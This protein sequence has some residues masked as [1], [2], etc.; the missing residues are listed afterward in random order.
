MINKQAVLEA[1]DIGAYYKAELRQEIKPKT[2]GWA[3]TLCCFHT[4]KN[5]SL[6]VNGENGGWICRAGCGSG[7]I[8]SFHMKKYNLDFKAA[9]KD[10]A[11]R[12]GVNGKKPEIKPF[13]TFDEVKAYKEKDG[14]K[15]DR[16][17]EYQNG[18]PLYLRV[19][20]KNDAGDKTAAYCT[21]TGK[22]FE[23]KRISK[24][25]LYNGTA[26]S[27]RP[28]DPVLKCEG[29]KDTDRLISLGFLAVTAGSVGDINK[30]VLKPLNKRQ[31][32]LCLDNDEP[33]KNATN[34][35][36]A[37][38]H[39]MD[40]N[41]KAISWPAEMNNPELKDVCDFFDKLGRTK[42][43]FLDLVSQAV[44]VPG[45]Q[46]PATEK[47]PG[48]SYFL[49]NYGNLCRYKKNSEGEPIPVKLAN[50]DARILEEA[51]ED[52]GLD[53]THKYTIEGKIKDLP[54]PIS[55]IPASQ[56][57]GMGWVHK[58]GAGAVIEPG[59]GCKDYVRHA[60]QT[61]SRDIRKTTCYTHTG[62]REI[63][64]VWVYLAGTG[65]IGGDDSILTHI[66]K[67]LG[68][69]HMP[70]HVE[71]SIE[72]EAIQ[73]SLSFLDVGKP[74]ITF[75]L[76]ATTFLAPLTTEL[77]PIP[78]FSAY[79]YGETGTLKTSITAAIVSHFGDFGKI[80][81]LQGFS[82]TANSLEKR[83]YIL[84]DSVMVLDDFHPSTQKKQAIAMEMTAER[85]IRAYANRTG[86]GRMNPDGS[87]KGCYDPRGMLF[88]TGEDLPGGQSTLA[89]LAV[90]EVTKGDIDKLKLAKLQTKLDIL[91]SA[92]TSYILWLQGQ[93]E[94]IKA[95]FKKQFV[96][97]RQKAYR[98]DNHSRMP[99]VVA[100][101]QFGLSTSLNWMVD[102]GVIDEKRAKELASK[103]WEIF[104]SLATRH[105]KR[106]SQDNPVSMFKEVVGTLLI[107]GRAR[108][109]PK[110]GYPE[111]KIIITG[112]ELIG[113]EDDTFYYFLPTAL[114]HMISQYYNT[115][116]K[117][118]PVTK[119]T[120]YEMLKN[121]GMVQAAVDTTTKPE[122][123]NGKNKR[124]LKVYKDKMPL[125][126]VIEVL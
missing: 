53:V 43:D 86:R 65:A 55:E 72:K 52:N 17:H 121:K 64:G 57:Y 20:Y 97:L 115:E 111:N 14:Y 99:E 125:P 1:L 45:D 96:M 11:A 8:I 107:Q 114:W 103:G 49:D 80:N 88:I 41:V 89:R 85:T 90:I 32:I 69:Y 110:S 10:L 68:R 16:Q 100:F 126:D 58:L 21:Q 84:K 47:Q 42:Q 62:W 28:D 23:M 7:D 101:L 38:L 26:L 6:S 39:G 124:I 48:D 123:I 37:I 94:E 91:P 19:I 76:L 36:A 31:V 105:S 46:V 63:N 29:E 102:K 83:A 25:V 73:T 81:K 35:A 44:D 82:D 70:A 4:E 75:P 18:N 122:L 27:E 3:L 87:D 118:F 50:F 74:E 61:R 95:D 71:P 67:E 112:T 59:Q 30:T 108:V 120:L 33:G 77:E 98:D 51:F 113:Y 9:L 66:P 93:L 78:N 109:E 22:G 56:L 60:I 119:N 2:D 24:P 104:I 15:Y 40:A 116:G 12:A 117:H 5:P 34:K 54:L 92:M 106:I 13:K 79:V